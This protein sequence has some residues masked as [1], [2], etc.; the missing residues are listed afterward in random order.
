MAVYTEVSF[1]QADRFV[2]GLG[3]GRLIALRG[4]TA[5][6]ENTNYFATTEQGEWVLTLFERLSSEELPFY[7]NYMQH[8]ARHALPVPQPQADAAGQILHQLNGRPAALVNRLRG[9]H[10]LAPDLQHIAQLG[11]M[12]AHLHL[13]GADFAGCQPHLRGLAWWIDTVPL[14]LPFL[15]DE[16][17]RLM[18]EEL[19]FQRAVAASGAAAALPH[20][21]IHADLFRDNV[22]F[23]EVDAQDRLSGLFDFFFAGIDSL[24]FDLAVCL[25]DWCIDQPSGR[26]V[27]EQAEA[28]CAA[29][30]QVRNLSGAELRLM[31][32]MLRA[33]ALRF[34]LSRLWDLHLPRD[35][36][37]L[38]ARDPTHF[39]RVLRDRIERPWHPPH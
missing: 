36:S 1:E 24:L 16:R 28:F 21:V 22:V 27:D 31:P 26:L 5:G 33:A 2:Q 29:Y 20:G 38:E 32:A 15:D 9:R 8:L 39:E 14:V 7:L 13:A 25:N 35:A 10:V 12:L 18:R 4:I 17:A 23:D 11:Q 3:R 34:W 19:A 6:I 37:L 30:G